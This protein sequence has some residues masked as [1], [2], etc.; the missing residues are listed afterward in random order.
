M[1][2]KKEQIIL[3]IPNVKNMEFGFDMLEWVTCDFDATYKQVSMLSPPIINKEKT[4]DTS[5]AVRSPLKK[6]WS[7]HV[8]IDF[9]LRII[10]NNI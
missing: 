3:H 2:I 10:N 7:P 8:V 6:N 5:M 4:V 1:P 9:S